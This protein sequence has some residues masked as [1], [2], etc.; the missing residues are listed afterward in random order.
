[1][2]VFPRS[3]L[4]RGDPMHCRRCGYPLLKGQ[5]TCT[6]CGAAEAARWWWRRAFVLILAGAALAATFAARFLRG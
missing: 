5:A 1:M 3:T 4:V 6:H 2:A